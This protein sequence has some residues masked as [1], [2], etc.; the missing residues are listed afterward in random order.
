MCEVDTFEDM[1]GIF[2][3]SS[4]DSAS[5]VQNEYVT[6]Q[7]GDSDAEDMPRT[8]LLFLMMTQQY[9]FS[10]YIIHTFVQIYE[11]ILE[12]LFIKRFALLSEV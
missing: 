1:V 12:I 3:S 8:S 9:Q 7:E 6:A 4:D 10:M 5:L 11:K 2:D